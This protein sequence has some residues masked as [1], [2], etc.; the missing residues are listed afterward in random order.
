MKHSGRCVGNREIAVSPVD[1]M[2]LQ[3]TGLKVKF[4]LCV[5]AF[6]TIRKEQ[7]FR[8]PSCDKLYV[9]G[10]TSKWGS[11]GLNQRWINHFII[12]LIHTT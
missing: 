5:L 10:V 4:R 3:S 11:F 6:D 8:S 1:C 2:C 9:N 12:Q 7:L